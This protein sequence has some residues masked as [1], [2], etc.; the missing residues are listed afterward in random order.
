MYAVLNS[1][2]CHRGS[3]GAFTT[4]RHKPTSR[5]STAALSGLPEDHGCL[6]YDSHV[7]CLRVVSDHPAHGGLGGWRHSLHEP[8]LF[9]AALQTF[10]QPSQRL[11]PA[12]TLDK[13][14]QVVQQPLSQRQPHQT[15]H[16]GAPT[17]RRGHPKARLSKL[18]PGRSH[19]P[20]PS[21]RNS[22]RS[23]R[24]HRAGR[25]RLSF[26]RSGACLPH[27]GRPRRHSH[28]GSKNADGQIVAHQIRTDTPSKSGKYVWLSSTRSSR[29]SR[30]GLAGPLTPTPYLR[31]PPP[32][33]ASG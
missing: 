16:P 11:A 13:V 21:G 18:G 5:Q 8:H 23:P 17:Q 10:M 29:G 1:I 24:R 15:P 4:Q 6:L 2:H 19:A 22:T 27:L 33:G 14:Y 9:Q 20:L 26:A 30:A 7:V 12:D 31:S 25:A 3:G 28:S 32:A